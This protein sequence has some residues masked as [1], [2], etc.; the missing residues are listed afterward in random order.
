VSEQSVEPGTEIDPGTPVTIT[1][2]PV[3]QGRG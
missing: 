3:E 2:K 1:C